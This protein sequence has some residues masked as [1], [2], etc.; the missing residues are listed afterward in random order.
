M[1]EINHFVR[2]EL[3]ESFSLNNKLFN[4]TTLKAHAHNLV[5]TGE[6]YEK[7]I[8]DFLLDWLEDEPY[9]I[10]HTSGSTG[11]PKAIKILKEHMVNSAKATGSFFKMH[12]RS[13]ALLCLSANYI[14]G[15]M[16]LVRAMTLGW[17]LDVVAPKVNPLDEV[18][19][20]YD[21]C[22]MV[23]MQLD[24]SINRLHLLKKLIVGGGAV[25]EHLIALIQGVNTKIYETYGM[26]ET[27][28]HI[29]ARRI[30]SKKKPI[31]DCFFK[32]LPQVIISIDHRN[33]LQIK[34]PLL[35]NDVLVTNDIVEL[36]TYKK[37]IWKGRFDNVIN[38]G[39]VKLFPE[40]IEKKL[41]L[42]IR[43]RFFVTSQP[44][45]QLGNKLILIIENITQPNSKEM[46]FNKINQVK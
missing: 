15:K 41:Q 4:E 40:Q 9:I 35:C 7:E 18:F 45:K 13:S 33:C 21:F 12:E 26:T 43:Q 38:S 11:A 14:A 10:V 6:D 24:N 46:F 29:A 17:K 20:Q 28:S 42:V 27:V 31:S 3:H 8:G 36:I 19:K 16:M 39:G 22:A 2:P 37:F 30:N 5:R 44:D 1:P 34:A 23:P 32:A 25:P